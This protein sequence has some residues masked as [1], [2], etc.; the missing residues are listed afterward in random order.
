MTREKPPD[1]AWDVWI[2]QLIQE[3]KN[4]GEF[5]QLEG[6]GKPIPGPR[7]QECWRKVKAQRK[8]VTRTA[9]VE[10]VYGL[11]PL[12]QTATLEYQ[13]HR[14]AIH[15]CR[16][17]GA[18]RALC[19]DHDHATGEP[20]GYLCRRHNTWLGQAGD[21]PAVFDSLAAYLR[22]PP[23]RDIRAGIAWIEKLNDPS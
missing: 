11:T 13:R 3:A 8:T 9:T 5:D 12:E 2:E 21:D 6:K 14:C 16:A 18:S 23:V 10:K 22:N 1:K 19:V 7:Y 20:R 15:G 17:R 4:A